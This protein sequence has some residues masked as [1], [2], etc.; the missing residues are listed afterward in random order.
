[1]QKGGYSTPDELVRTALRTLEEIEG[2]PLESLAP[3]TLAAIERAEAQSARGEGQPWELA[4]EEFRARY[5]K[6]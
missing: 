5:L 4:R 3:Q 6:K 2:E 1:M